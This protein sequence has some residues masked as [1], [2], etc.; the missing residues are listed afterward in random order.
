ML[1]QHSKINEGI[2]VTRV[3][4]FQVVISLVLI[5]EDCLIFILMCYL[6]NQ[7]KKAKL[8]S[9]QDNKKDKETGL[10]QGCRHGHLGGYF[11]NLGKKR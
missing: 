4:R 5:F 11:N 6:Y 10:R 7:E 3:V 1:E 2:E 9:L 8:F